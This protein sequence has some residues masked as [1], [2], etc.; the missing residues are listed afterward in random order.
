MPLLLTEVPLVQVFTLHH[1]LHVM[2]G[3]TSIQTA[4]HLLEIVTMSS[5]HIILLKSLMRYKFQ[6]QTV[7]VT[8]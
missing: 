6:F 1:L 2:Q 5:Q 3:V 4:L 8:S 7:V